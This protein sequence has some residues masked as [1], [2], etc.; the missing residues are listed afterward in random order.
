MRKFLSNKNGYYVY[1]VDDKYIVQMD[2]GDHLGHI[3]QFTITEE[4]Y[5]KLQK[6]LE[7]VK[8]AYK[9]FDHSTLVILPSGKAWGTSNL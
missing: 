8:G 9:E 2:S 3:Y 6:S 5:L 7:D 1:L 4:Q